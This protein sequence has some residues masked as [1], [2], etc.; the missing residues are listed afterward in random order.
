MSG[1]SMSVQRL[2]AELR[3][4]PP[5][6]KVCFVAHDQSPD[7]GEFDGGVH[8]VSTAPVALKARGYGVYL[9]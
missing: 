2:I 3:K 8:Y 6:S 5:R 1:H 9:S 7:S 4:Y